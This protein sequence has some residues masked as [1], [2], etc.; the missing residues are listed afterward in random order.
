MA[1]LKSILVPIDGS[2]SSLKGLELAIK[3]AKPSNAK[4]TGINVIRYSL[5]FSFPVS[6]EVRKQHRKSAEQIVEEAK[7]KVKKNNVNFVGKII[8]GESIGRE[9]TNYASLKNIDL[10]VIGS[11]GPE[12]RH[13]IFLGSV[14]NYVL[15]K[16]KIPITIVK[17]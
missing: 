2:K 17:G 7:K 5:G 8:Q 11:K 15:H 12:P 6:S 9:I 4:I 1:P 3:I 13:E 10:I 14:A 16:S